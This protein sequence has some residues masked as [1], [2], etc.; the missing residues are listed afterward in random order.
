MR[1]DSGSGGTSGSA[2]DADPEVIAAD[3]EATREEMRLNIEAIQERLDPQQLSQQAT[4]VT[5][6]AK[7]RPPKSL[8]RPSRQGCGEVR[9]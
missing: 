4:E 8:S 9:D 6:Q 5:E 7:K 3:I 1:A 2:A